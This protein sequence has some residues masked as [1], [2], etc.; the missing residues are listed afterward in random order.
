MFFWL[1]D[2]RDVLGGEV[3][4]EEYAVCVE[5]LGE[6]G[7]R[8]E[9]LV[10]GDRSIIARAMSLDIS[11]KAKTYY[12]SVLAKYATLGGLH[13]E[14]RRVFVSTGCCAPA[15][16]NGVWTIPLSAFSDVSSVASCIMVVEHMYDYTVIL[17]LV[18]IHLAQVGLASSV[19][20]NLFPAAGGGGGTH[21]SLSMYQRDVR[22]LGI[23][24]L[25]SDRSHVYDALGNT[26]GTCKR[27]FAESWRWRMH[28]VCG[29]ELENLIPPGVLK[30]VGL[31]SPYVDDAYY[32]NE[33]WPVMGYVDIKSGDSICRFRKIDR[34]NRSF[35]ETS[36]VIDRRFSAIS[37][38][39]E[40]EPCARDACLLCR[41]AD[42]MLSDL[43]G[44]IH[45]SEFRKMRKLP[46]RVKALDELIDD[47]VA[48]GAAARWHFT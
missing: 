18:D 42:S 11:R 37:I 26:A 10:F 29:R 47:V 40:D 32:S 12:A 41:S 39:D 46:Q 15:A 36:D 19:G 14:V 22:R 16:E 6:A 45:G 24:V 9:H 28:I 34:G 8:K 48:A 25:D 17:G 5:N 27:V 38:C 13:R 20:I 35:V 7:Y 2:E 44:R 30:A 31:L 23:C 3:Q 43:A 1:K 33:R 21:L 4:F